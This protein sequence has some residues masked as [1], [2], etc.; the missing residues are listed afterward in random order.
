MKIVAIVDGTSG[1][2]SMLLPS[3]LLAA[4]TTTGLPSK[5]LSDS[6][7]RSKAIDLG[8]WPGTTIGDRDLLSARATTPDS[9][10]TRGS[11]YLLA[12][13]AIAYTAIA[14]I[15]TIAVA[16]LDRRREFGLQRLTGST[17]RQV[18][19]ML[20]LEAPGDRGP[21]PGARP[22]RSRLHA[23]SRSPS[24]PAAGRSRPDRL[25]LVAWIGV[26]L[27]LVLPTTAITGRIA[28][29]ASRWTQ[30]AAVG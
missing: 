1:Y 27:L 23:S 17:R 20:Y 16:V 9:G 7:R 10:S 5:L 19:E 24:P 3:A 14:S 25:D 6:P 13:I 18:C 22:D 28:M 15:N 12:G 21:R 30:S 8:Q 4:H 26:V 11:R 2:E 29:R